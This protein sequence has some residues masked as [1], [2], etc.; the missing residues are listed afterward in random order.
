MARHKEFD[1]ETALE[2]A[3]HTFWAGGFDGTSTQDLVDT[4]GINRSSLYATFHSKAEL[5]ARALQR[6]GE[7]VPRWP[8]LDGPGPLR[9]KLRAVLLELVAAEIDP[10]LSRGCFACKAAVERGPSDAR[11]RRLVSTAFGGVREVL[12]E[13]LTEARDRGELAADAD[14]EMIASSLLVTIEGLH[15]VAA[16]TRDRRVLEQAVEA[17][18]GAL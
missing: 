10:D 8:Q 13:A 11:V 3:M 16:G 18:I 15:V 9:S 5:Y 12:A 14:V 1:P 2:R 17:A 6:Y 4:L 7:G